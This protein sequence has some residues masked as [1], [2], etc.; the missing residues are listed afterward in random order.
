[1]EGHT[2]MLEKWEGRSKII[3]QMVSE[4]VVIDATDKTEWNIRFDK[5]PT[6]VAT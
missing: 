1:M 3:A 6:K 5:N 2:G 4:E